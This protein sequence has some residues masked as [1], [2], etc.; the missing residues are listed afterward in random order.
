MKPG[1][2]GSMPMATEGIIL[3]SMLLGHLAFVPF[4][5]QG[6][7]STNA[8]SDG[9]QQSGNL[10]A[11]VAPPAEAKWVYTAPENFLGM[12]TSSPVVDGDNI[13]AAFSDALQRATLV[14]L[15]RQTGLQRWAFYGKKPKL[16]QMISTPCLAEGKLYFG[17]G[18]HDDQD[19]HVFCVDAET[20]KEVWNFKT[21]GQTESSPAVVN[22]KVYIGAGN[23]GVTVFEL[24]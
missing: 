17:E 22:G 18:F 8:A 6:G 20:G 12:F 9:N 7:I 10:S 16:R 14:R 3:G 24:H 19:C 13:Y 21:A 2:F 23:D 15:D 4:I 11:K 1:L 5:I